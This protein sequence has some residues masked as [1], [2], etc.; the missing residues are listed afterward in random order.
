MPWCGVWA[1]SGAGWWWILP[2]V[3]IVVMGAMFFLCFRRAGCMG[4]RT[5]GSGEVAGLQREVE[6]LKQEVRKLTGNPR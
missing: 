4:G 6:E 2:L 3:G 1:T 5:R